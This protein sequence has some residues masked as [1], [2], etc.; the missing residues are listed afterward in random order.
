TRRGL[1]LLCTEKS[2][3]IISFSVRSSF[4][5]ADLGL[6]AA[7]PQ[8]TLPGSRG[9]QQRAGAN[10]PPKTDWGSDSFTL[11]NVA[12]PRDFIKSF[13]TKGQKKRG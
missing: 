7:K 1:L 5:R 9:F 6:I 13:L 3:K 4:W 11:Y 8:R 10:M 12:H 2:S